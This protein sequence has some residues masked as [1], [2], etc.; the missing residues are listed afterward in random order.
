MLAELKSSMEGQCCKSGFVRASRPVKHS[1]GCTPVGGRHSLSTHCSV[2]RS[3]SC[4]TG[5]PCVCPGN[6]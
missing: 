1:R 3:R 5:L 6:R 2:G 4:S